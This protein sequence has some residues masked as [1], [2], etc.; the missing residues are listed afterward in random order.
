MYEGQSITIRKIHHRN[1]DFIGIFFEWNQEIIDQVKRLPDRVYSNSQK[2]WY[3][4]YS[5]AHFQNLIDLFGFK[6]AD[7]PFSL[8]DRESGTIAATPAKDDHTGISSLEEH[9]VIASTSGWTEAADIQENEADQLQIT[10]SGNQFFIKMPYDPLDVS[11]VKS[12]SGSYWNPKHG[13]WVVR[14]NENQLRALQEHFGYWD[15]NRFLQIL[16]LILRRTDPYVVELFTT[17]EFPDKMLVRIKGYGADV[18]WI[19]SAPHREYDQALR[20]WIMP[21]DQGIVDR[22]VTHFTKAGAKVINRLPMKENSIKAILPSLEEKKRFLLTKYPSNQRPV[23]EDLVDTLIRKRYSWNTITGYVRSFQRYVDYLNLVNVKESDAKDVNRYLSMLAGLKVSESMIH[24]AVNAI[25]FYYEQVNFRLDFKIEQIKRPKRSHT[26]PHFLSIG[27]VD[28]LLRAL[29]NLKHLAIL[30]TLYSGGLRLSELLNLRNQDIYW[31]RNQIFIRS[32][33]GKKDRIV[34]LS[35]NLKNLLVYYYDE[36]QPRYWLFE[37]QNEKEPYSARSVQAV[38]KHAAKKAGLTR[39]VTP[40]TLRHCFATHLL[41]HGT[42][43]RFIQEMLG[44]KDIKTT[45]I[46]THVT[47]R[48]LSS[49]QS[50]LDKLI[51]DKHFIKKPQE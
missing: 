40:H 20:R 36:Y 18:E 35:E 32:G 48:S 19:K 37:G 30:Y 9:S 28:R 12:L 45:M 2:C 22:L 21:L 51:L 41:D 31:G 27:E 33:K 3:L 10:F 7:Y 26:L 39:K 16:E 38:V 15:K 5:V 47:N 14:G 43:I 17:P 34:M 6:M 1:E 13:N 4:P 8:L 42:D 49:I 24:T 11:F 50:P 25:K 46:Y 29:D 23:L 44:H